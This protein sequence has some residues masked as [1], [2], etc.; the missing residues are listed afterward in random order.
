MVGVPEAAQ[1]IVADHAMTLAR[2]H[3]S[4]W[5]TVGTTTAGDK[6]SD[7]VPNKNGATCQLWGS[8]WVSDMDTLSSIVKLGF[9][10]ITC[11]K[12]TWILKDEIAVCYLWSIDPDDPNEKAGVAVWSNLEIFHT[13]QQVG[14]R[15]DPDGPMAYLA[16][17]SKGGST[18]IAGK[19]A[20]IVEVGSDWLRLIGDGLSG[21]V[22]PQFC[23]HTA[24][25]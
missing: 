9:L 6:F 24:K 20:T 17:M 23:H 4:S 14:K 5:S 13:A 18:F 10:R 16:I 25:K 19:K 1:P 22:E 21:Y 7:L 15:T 12:K 8:M 3:Y 11:P 2:Q